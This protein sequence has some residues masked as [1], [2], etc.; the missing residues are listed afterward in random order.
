MTERKITASD[1]QDYTVEFVPF[2]DIKPSPEN[3][4]L[5]GNTHDE[6]QLKDLVSSIE[7]R[8]LDEPI[9]VSADN[10]VMSGHRRRV[11]LRRLGIHLVPVRRKS[12]SRAENRG[13]WPRILAEYNTQ[14]VKTPGMLLREALLRRQPDNAV[15]LLERHRER[16]RE[17]ITANF[18]PVNRPKEIK[19]ISKAKKPFLK[20]VKK[21]VDE[22]VEFWP[23]T[24]RLIHYQ[25][26]NDPPPIAAYQRSSKTAEDLIY[27]N[28]RKSYE[29]LIK[30]LKQAR[31]FGE[32]SM[33]AI[34]D[35]TRP[36]KRNAG[37]DD[38]KDFV[39]QEMSGFLNGYRLDLQREQPRHIEVMGEKNTLLNILGPICT[40]YCVPFF[41]G[42]GYCSTPVWRDVARRF[43][44]SGK[45]EMTLIVAS[46]FDPEG[47]DLAEDAIA[48]LRELW[49]I[50]VDYHRLGVTRDQINALNLAADFNPAKDTSTR[51]KRFV[52]ETGSE[53]TWE[54]EAL[55]PAYLQKQLCAAIEANMDMEV[56]EAAIERE[57]QDAEE[58]RNIRSELMQDLS[59]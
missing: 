40:D 36:Q 28:D 31:Y 13:E 26:L 41:L 54:L 51:F 30:L 12:I 19:P 3:T 59:C 25:L 20:A 4:D 6:Q 55:P 9:I 53:K 52:R 45:S 58:L 5:Y 8:G 42:R 1:F 49:D 34:D 33:S 47:L 23:L 24:V 48:S 39:D 37:F 21:V 18:T 57:E 15:D 50:P 38:V 44:Q 46:D 35:P 29:A 22:M 14:R 17:S 16:S 43:K 10:Y 7:R 32:V 56:Y 2:R 11:A 27:R